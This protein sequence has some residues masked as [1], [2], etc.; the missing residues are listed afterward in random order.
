MRIAEQDR[1]DLTSFSLKHVTSLY[2]DEEEI[3]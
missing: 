1:L 2:P 3:V